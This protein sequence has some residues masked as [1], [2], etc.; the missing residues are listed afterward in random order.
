M[1]ALQLGQPVGLLQRGVELAGRDAPR[2]GHSA[3]RASSSASVAWSPCASTTA[4]S[5]RSRRTCAS[6]TGWN[7]CSK[8]VQLIR[9]GSGT[10][11]RSR[12]SAG[13]PATPAPR[14]CW[15][16][17]SA[18]SA[19]AGPGRRPRARLRARGPA[20]TAARSASRLSKS[21]TS[22][23]KASSSAGSS[24]RF[25]S[26]SVTRTWRVWPRRDSS[27]WSSG[28]LTSALGALAR[29]E[30]HDPLLEVRDRLVL[31]Q[32]EVVGLRG[33]RLAVL[34][35]RHLDPDHLPGRGLQSPSTGIQAAFCSWI[36][37]SCSS[38]ASSATGG[39]AALEP[40]AARPLQLELGPHLDQQ[41][42]LD[43]A[44]VLELEVPDR[45]IGDRLERLGGLGG[46]PALADD[47]LEHGLADGVAEPLA[48]DGLGRLARAE[49]GQPGAL[50]VVLEPPWPRPPA[51][52]PPGR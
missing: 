17:R 35:R 51:P 23:A 37:A 1:A 27:G 52:G 11:R 41:L 29:E 4:S 44:A 49:P 43:R 18:R 24:W 5:T 50:G 31:A 45:G 42:E 28:N 20:R 9:A 6:A 13:A 25:T 2:L 36:R 47:F 39:L 32:H 14:R 22:R 8:P 3:I 40:E 21:P 19:P 16:R 10:S 26:C 33:A 48:D 38:T 34:D 30:R 7:C 46:L 12:A 15:P